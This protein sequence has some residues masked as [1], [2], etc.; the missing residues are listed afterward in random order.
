MRT[1]L[2]LCLLFSAPLLMPSNTVVAASAA[3]SPGM[4]VGRVVDANGA[5]VADA[6][7]QIEMTLR[8]GRTYMLETSTNRRGVFGF[9]EVVRKVERPHTQEAVTGSCDAE[10]IRDHEG[11]DAVVM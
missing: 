9:E 5:P 3:H 7:V 2:T 10:A 6:R 11:V 4:M 8:S 1:L